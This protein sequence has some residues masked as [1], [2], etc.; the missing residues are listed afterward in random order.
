MRSLLEQILLN[1]HGV[2]DL[3]PWGADEEKIAI[4]ACIDSLHLAKLDAR[5]DLLK[6]ILHVCGSGSIAIIGPHGGRSVTLTFLENG[7]QFSTGGASTPLS[8]DNAKIRL[9]QLYEKARG[10]ASR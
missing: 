2:L 6:I 7:Y 5:D 1:E 3:E 4:G 9:R 10:R 8:I